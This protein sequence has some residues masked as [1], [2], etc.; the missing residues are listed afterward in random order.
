MPLPSLDIIIVNWNAGRWLT[1]CLRAVASAAPTACTLQRV[2]VID[3]ASTDDSCDALPAP[4]ARLPLTLVRNASNRGFAA[5]CNQGA[6]GSRA[7]Y[8]LF[9]NPDT[10]ATTAALDGVIQLLE[11][12]ASAGVDIG[13]VWMEG[14][15]G[16]QTLWLRAFPTARTFMLQALGLRQQWTRDVDL[17]VPPRT[18]DPLGPLEVSIVGGAFFAIRRPLF[19]ALH[20]FDERFFMYFDEV[21]L[22]RRARERGARAML[23]RNVTIYHHNGACSDRVPAMRLFYLLRSRLRYA[24]RHFSVP[25]TI[26]LA[27]LM[28]TYEPALRLA[29]AALGRGPERIGE[30]AEAYARFAA[31]LA[32]LGGD[33]RGVVRGGSVDRRARAQDTRWRDARMQDVDTRDGRTQD[34]Q[35]QDARA[36]DA[37]AKEEHHHVP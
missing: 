4:D 2:I 33:D 1:D 16:A 35:A 9:L 34:G 24:R 22:C 7:D 28:C 27:G 15:A 19:E 32:G 36:K 18:A 26:L 37:P 14:H 12:Q 13:G 11:Q 17:G 21:D 6:A 23:A 5:A 8:L 3:N 20:G 30:V 10:V 29:R 25:Q 31:S